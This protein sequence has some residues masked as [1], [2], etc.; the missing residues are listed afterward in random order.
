MRYDLVLLDFDGTFT[1]VEKE[2]GPFFEA[3]LADVRELLGPGFESEWEQAA[4]TMSADP[5]NHGWLHEGRIVAPGNADP[6]LRATVVINMVLDRRGLYLEGNARTDLLQRLY[7]DNYPK[8]D[9]VFRP[10]AKRVVEALLASGVPTFVVTNSATSDVQR[11]IDKLSPTNRDRLT[12]HGNA[13]KFFVQDPEPLDARF[14]ALPATMAVE[15]LRRPI[16][17]RRGRYYEVLRGIW[18]KTGI[19]PERTL[20]AGDIFELDLAL[21]A[22]LGAHVQL[23]LKDKT[24]DFERR[25]IAQLEHGEASE[26]LGGILHR[27]GLA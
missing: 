22:H 11:K 23:V 4:A 9:T 14:E 18:E 7:H 2:A 25:A 17:V 3:Y 16:Y 19:S 13:R 10:D 15:G 5:A 1:D 27:V 20:V 21:P 6:Y 26:D 8:A 24:E 12:V